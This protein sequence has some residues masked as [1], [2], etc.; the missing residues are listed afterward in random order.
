MSRPLTLVRF[1]ILGALSL[2][3]FAIGPFAAAA[4]L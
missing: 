4:S 1:S 3:S 2:K